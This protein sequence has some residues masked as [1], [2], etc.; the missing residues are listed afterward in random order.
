[1]S[2]GQSQSRRTVSRAA[3]TIIAEEEGDK[4]HQD[5]CKLP[6]QGEMARSWEESSPDLWVK[7]VQGLPPE[8]LKFALNASLNTLPTNAVLHTWGK[9]PGDPLRR[10]RSKQLPGRYG[11]PKVQ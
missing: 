9:K 6:A 5:L 10:A 1:M 3:K 11:S 7:A 2:G 8:P 4:R